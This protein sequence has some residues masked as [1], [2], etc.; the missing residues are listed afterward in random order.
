MGTYTG[1]EIAV[2]GMAGRFPEA[3]NIDQY[4]EN[5]MQGKDCIST[6]SKVDA[7]N[8]GETAD[9]LNQ[10]T[11]VK[12]HAYLRNKEYFDATFFNYLPDEAEL[13]D[14][15]VRIYH[16]VC[17]EALE[18]SGYSAGRDRH[19]IGV[20]ASGSPNPR[21]IL[22]AANKNKEGLIDEFTAAHLW[23]VTFLSSR[24]AYKLDLK[25]PTI[26]TQTACSSSL[27]AIHQACSSLLLGECNMALAGG[28]CIK[29][30]SKKGYLYQQ[31]MILS[32]DG[33]CRPFDENSSGTVAGEGVGVVVLKR[34]KD[35]MN[36]NDRIYAIIKGSAINNDGSGKVGYTAPSVQGQAEVI[37]GALR[38]AQLT[39]NKISYVE[40]HGTATQLGDPIEIEALS[41]VYNKETTRYCFIGS[42]KSNIGHL[43]CAAGVAGFIK[44]VLAIKNR[45]IPATLHFN[46]PNPKID[47]KDEVLQVTP[48]LTGWPDESNILRAGVSSFGIGGTN[49]HLIL[50]E[51]PPQQTSGEGRAFQMVAWSAKTKSELEQ[52]GA[53]LLNFLQHNPG[54]SLPDLEYTM[55]QR[56]ERFPYRKMLV[57]K[58]VPEAIRKIEA[59]EV[60]ETETIDLQ[61]SLQHTIFM[62]SGQGAQYPRMAYDLYQQEIFFKDTMDECFALAVLYTKHDFKQVWLGESETNAIRHTEFTQPLLFMVEYAMARLLMHWGIKPDYMIGHSIGEYVAACLS[63]VFKL[64]DALRLVI[65]R[66]QLMGSL[67]EGAMLS[68]QADLPT[69]APLLKRISD[70]ELAVVNGTAA[71]VV[72]GTD[73][74][75]DRLIAALKKM[76]VNSKKLNTS[77]AFHSFMMEPILK[78]FEAEVASVVIQKPS[79]AYVSN[80]TGQLVS[81]DQIGDVAYW[82]KHLRN[83]VLFAE[84]INTLLA[85]GKA[86]CIEIGPGMSLLNHVAGSPY[87][88]KKHTLTNTIRQQYQNIHDT[89]YLIEK[90]GKLWLAGITIHWDSFYQGQF[91]QNLSL[92]TYSF[93]K[94]VYTTNFNINKLLDDVDVNNFREV[95]N[96]LPQVG[97][98]AYLNVSGWKRSI[99][100]PVD[101][102]DKKRHIL[103]FPGAESTVRLLVEH[104]INQGHW[105]IMVEA[106]SKFLVSGNLMQMNLLSHDHYKKLW[107]YLGKIGKKID[108][109]VYAETFTKNPGVNEYDVIENRLSEGYIGFAMLLKSV[110]DFASRNK[111]SISVLTNHLVAVNEDDLLDPLKGTLLGPAKIVPSEISSVQCKVI[112]WAVPSTA[113]VEQDEYMARL[114]DEIFYECEDPLVAFRLKN[115]WIQ[116]FEPITELG[117]VSSEVY[118]QSGNTYLIVGGLGGMGFAIA[119]DLVLQQKANIIIIHRSDFPKEEVWGDWISSSD[120]ENETREKILRL[121]EMKSTGCTVIL[122]QMNVSEETAVQWWASDLNASS[123]KLNGI[124]W[125]AGEADYGGVIQNR[126]SQDYLRYL[127]SKVHGILLFEKFLD[128]KSLDFLALFSSIGNTFYQHKFGQVAYNAANEF[129]ENYAVWIRQK[130]GIHA[131]AINWCDWL[132]V[133]MT[134]NIK[135]K[136]MQTASSG[137]INA[138]IEHAIY[139][140]EGVQLFHSC[141]HYNVPVVSVY[142][143]DIRRALRWHKDNV[144]RVQNEWNASDATMSKLAKESIKEDALLSVFAKFFGNDRIQVTDDFFELGGDSLK[145]MSLVG[146]LN[147]RFNTQLSIGDLYRFSNVKKLLV[148]I[149]EKGQSDEE[150]PIP[151]VGKKD[152]YTLSTEQRRLFFL[153][154]LNPLDISYNETK[155]LW[156]HG[157]L[158]YDKLKEVFQ[159]LVS[160]H[161]CLRTLFVMGED[162]IP[163]QKIIADGKANIDVYFYGWDGR[164]TEEIVQAF[165]KPFDL[166][167]DILLRVAVFKKSAKEYLLIFDSHHIVLDGVSKQIL[168]RELFDAYAGKTLPANKI[169]YKDYAEWQQSVHHREV[170][171][172]KREFWLA[173]FD[174]EIDELNLPIDNPRDGELKRDGGIVELLMDSDLTEQLRNVAREEGTTMFNVL[175]MAYAILLSKVS[176]QEDLVVGIPVTNRIQTELD[177]IVGMFVETLPIRL[178]PAGNFSIQVFLD[179]VKN[180]TLAGIEHVGYS[181][182]DLMDDL[183]ISRIP[184]RNPLFDVMFVYE[185][186]IVQPWTVDGLI[187]EETASKVKCARHDLTVLAIEG[188]T[189]L[190]IHFIYASDLFL[191]PTIQRLATYF[192]C[193]LRAVVADRKRILSAIDMLPEQE[194]NQLFQFGSQST[195]SLPEG[196]TIVHL[197]K[198]RVRA[199]PQGIALIVDSEKVTYAA[200]NRHTNAIA[201]EIRKRELGK[202]AR[203]ALLFEPSIALVAAMLGTMQAG[204]VYIP[205]SP[206]AGNNRNVRII[207][208]ADAA[209]VLIQENLFDEKSTYI[210]SVTGVSSMAVG[211]EDVGDDLPKSEQAVYSRADDAAYIIY[212]SGTT[213]EPKGVEIGHRSL[214]NYASWKAR[215]HQLTTEDTCLQLVPHHFDGF[216]ANFYPVLMAG[217]AM[218]LISNRYAH[219]TDYIARAIH[220]EMVTGFSLTPGMYTSILQEFER[221]SVPPRLRYV[222]L[223][224][225]SASK[226]LI[227]KSH[228]ILPQVQLGNEYGPTE[229]TVAATFH[230]CLTEVLPAVIGKPI[231][232]AR[233][234]LLGRHHEL[235]PVGV[236]GELHIG[237]AGLARGYVGDPDLTHKKFIDDP[238]NPGSKLYK[239]GDLGRWRKDGTLEILGRVDKQL[240]IRGY[241]IEPAE[242]ESCLEKYPTIEEAVVIVQKQANRKILVA[243]L[244]TKST[245][246]DHDLKAFLAAELPDFMI[247][248][249]YVLL[250]CI[251]LTHTGKINYQHLPLPK[252]H[253]A[254][255]HPPVSEEEIALATVWQQVLGNNKIGVNDNFFACG[256][257]SIKSI[258]VSARLRSE[259]Y[260]LSVKDIFANQTI[261]KMALVLKRINEYADQAP[262]V[263]EV[264]WSPIQAWFI[265]GSIEF[266][267]HF[268]QTV[269]VNF[270]EPIQKIT[271]E[272]IFQKL[273]DHHDMLRA[274]VKSENGRLFQEILRAR[275]IPVV[276]EEYD[277]REENE[278]NRFINESAERGQAGIVLSTGPLMKM[279]LFQG[280]DG[281]RLLI[282]IHHLIVDGISWRILFEDIQQLHNQIKKRLPLALPPKTSSYRDWS[283]CIAHYAASADHQTATAYWEKT[284]EVPAWKPTPVVENASNTY[285][286]QEKISFALTFRETEILLKEIHHVF[287]TQTNDLLLVAFMRAVKKRYHANSVW[288]D[289][290][291]HGRTNLDQTIDITRTVGWFTT[292][293][294]VMLQADVDD[295]DVIIKRT[296]ELLRC[297]PN[298]GIDYL[299]KRMNDPCDSNKSN[300]AISF[301]YLGQFDEDISRTSFMVERGSVG[302]DISLKECRLYDWEIAGIVMDQQLHMSITFSRHQYLR[303]EIESFMEDYKIE[304][305]NLVLY[306]MAQSRTY[307]TPYDVTHT[308]ISLAQLETLEQQFELEDA[309]PLTPMQEGM[310]FHS[311]L[312][313]DAGHYVE[314]MVLQI[315]GRMNINAIEKSLVQLVNHYEVLRTVFWHQGFEKPLQLVLKKGRPQFSFFDIREEVRLDGTGKVLA[316]YQLEDREDRFLLT[317][318]N[319]LRLTVLQTDL[320]EY[321][322]VWTHH[323]I[324]MDGWCAAIIWRTFCEFYEAAISGKDL[325]LP[326]AGRYADYITWLARQDYKKSEEFW[327]KRLDGFEKSSLISF[328]QRVSTEQ[329]SFQLA[330]ADIFLNEVFTQS[331][332]KVARD[333]G[334]TLNVLFQAAWAVLLSKYNHTDDVLFGAVVS[335]RPPELNGIEEMIGLFINTIPVRVKFEDS[336]LSINQLMSRLQHES[337]EAESFHYQPLAALQQ[338][339]SLG[340]NLL[341]HIMVF[342]SYP[343]SEKILQ[344]TSDEPGTIG[345]KEISVFEQSNYDLVIIVVPGNSLRIKIDYNGSVYSNESIQR[346]LLHFQQILRQ[347]ASGKNMLVSEIDLLGEE[348]R[349]YLKD[350][351]DHTT[352]NYP[353]AETITDLFQKQVHRTPDNIAVKFQSHEL[354]YR[355]LDD[356]SSQLANTLVRL[357]V[358]SNDVVGLLTHRSHETIIAILSILKAGGGYMPIDAEYPIARQQY[359]IKDSGTRLILTTRGCDLQVD[360]GIVIVYMEDV[361]LEPL[362]QV[363]HRAVPSDLCY[364]IYTSG[365]TGSPKGVMVEHR[366]VVRL[367]FNDDFQFD[368]GADDVW[369]MFHSQCFDFS[370]WEM[371]G[372]LLFGGKLIV[373][374]RAL[375]IDTAQFVKLV[376]EEGVTVL[377]QTPSAFYNF[378]SEAC[379]SQ[380]ALKLRYVIFGGEALSPGKLQLWR[381]RY[382]GVC[383]VNMFGITETTVHVTYKEIGNEEVEHNICNIGRP[384]PTLSA[385]I[386]DKNLCL[387]PQGCIGELHVGGAGVSRG[388]LGKVEL[389]AEKFIENPFRSGDR[390]YRTG[391]L[392]RLLPQGDIEYL[393]RVDQQVQLRG[394]R[395]E[396]GEIENQLCR[397]SDISDAAVLMKTVGDDSFL[398][399]YYV[400]DDLIADA[401]IRD[402]LADAIPDYMIPTRYVRLNQLPMTVNGKL[403]R[404]SFPDPFTSQEEIVKPDNDIERKLCGI[405]ADVLSMDQAKISVK[406]NFFSLGGHSLKATLL[407]NKINHE[408][409]VDFP[410]IEIFNKQNIK[411]LSDYL[412]TMLQLGDALTHKEGIIEFEL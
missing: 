279:K 222:V 20:F 12:A 143:G 261:R 278:P 372:A 86:C 164:T 324:L 364:V 289:L 345:I 30:Y 392:T 385:Y 198:E 337:M 220:R 71:I 176:N 36:D 116:H 96:E 408:F 173:Q 350:A 329:N 100:A 246:T 11:Y 115:R 217:G 156:I 359:M 174:E 137:E 24:I 276:V 179:Q 402:F 412:I 390:L 237:G 342:E 323:H 3:D 401:L 113:V 68:I 81:H 114:V 252:A 127:Q 67:A 52:N 264:P 112:D 298:E 305:Q 65:K 404:Q 87:K 66:G 362:G 105:V 354:T 38:M 2:I 352:V 102:G 47:F 73:I 224:G 367:F 97:I 201:H 219:N 397:H 236:S 16:E 307:L 178:T 274:V 92:P 339:N 142:K 288:V 273:L 282:I 216:C 123:I 78:E 187:I 205:L 84:G 7:A 132:D 158:D 275:D 189:Q 384:I 206:H 4:W 57:C 82:S 63:G 257:D 106:A 332:I 69:I 163:H 28:A 241:R 291:G 212:T 229:A 89:C 366:N 399:A 209:W 95:S 211:N 148:Y 234:Y 197:L 72:A 21:W 283:T 360:E 200:L 296:K 411:N 321:T 138:T 175:L 77:H 192:E 405:W 258:Q 319:L 119:N 167:S 249:A 309:Y 290:E 374:P 245:L 322:F 15:Q 248:E 181:L 395:V 153:Q 375:A 240:K 351:L 226:A 162:N 308:D 180:R 141:L 171:L 17:W 54:V 13:M 203:I 75:V 191:H 145:A 393:G 34:L 284:R 56:R 227:R 170:M 348:E 271:L 193:I 120:L 363:E 295:I 254:D 338:I 44:T 213:G 125:A 260:E 23:D 91:R 228:T 136:Q 130:A 373:I 277:L 35:A 196:K 40:T 221:D 46:K 310:F 39:A 410:L 117:R 37:K 107:S 43:D 166:A 215:T 151:L 169:T 369:T 377:N 110:A 230:S 149:L 316:R 383:L 334:V 168:Q 232:N 185:K 19:H 398:I 33:K 129:L 144:H 157:K 263:G 361:L 320:H 118:I 160:R 121:V 297:V 139:P 74:G 376:Q 9:L 8:E 378:S 231:D 371:Y 154:H 388:Y 27:V 327:K 64:E 403:D 204:C 109:I 103:I 29:N 61:E 218:L 5:L 88:G 233:V 285:A 172:G 108:C 300:A 159:I 62:F 317:E 31:G 304:L 253:E 161:E 265:Q 190:A 49:A 122:H 344:G 356:R 135:K 53:N 165:V 280:H 45:K 259:G 210:K 281:S 111:L 152:Y 199:N 400:S 32:R 335:G 188:E 328:Q 341:N 251:P 299:V 25:G 268:S 409:D 262:V 247:P 314:Q 48:T 126:K 98:D 255:F 301:N 326:K 93:A 336:S 85:L 155:V 346:L 287:R 318:G 14:P 42:V 357:G 131:F 243:Y 313:P 302:Q 270:S 330:S 389:T 58:D 184:G 349:H 60:N 391:D 347:V 235:L 104:L 242:I 292:I 355:Q 325:Y 134:Y 407:V 79:I 1:L 147:R 26:Y 208:D 50:E 183:R 101:K 214:L 340:S 146:R 202:Q 394:F 311:I 396:P 358:R 207:S 379:N 22:H 124:I 10:E 99:P 331:L 381:S 94:T 80:V 186:T 406:A 386:L 294:P 293:Y 90:I 244:V 239:S 76:S 59:D 6:F 266:K 41:R 140:E 18:D 150:S 133:G 333:T 267:S 225:E 353:A 128:F 365:T 70:V 55:L 194:K 343:V 223:G 182:E 306:C 382:S 312:T 368:F 238:F 303:N 387:V 269:V 250:P 380:V 315:E 51:A 256:G 286:D 370:V 195:N 83:T 177:R 272:L